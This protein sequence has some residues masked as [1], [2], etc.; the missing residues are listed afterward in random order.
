MLTTTP[1]QP[2]SAIIVDDHYHAIELLSNHITKAPAIQLQQ[3]F[4][5]PVLA[6]QFVQNTPVDLVFLDVDMQELSGLEFLDII[7]NKS[8][9]ILTTGHEKYAKN[10]YEYDAVIDYL[11]K[12]IKLDRFLK[13]VQK[14]VNSICPGSAAPVD[15]EENY[16]LVKTETK[17]KLQKIAFSE[18]IYIASDKNYVSI[19]T[20]DKRITS[21]MD[22]TALH[23]RLPQNQ[24]FRVHKSYIIALNKIDS[25]EKSA[26]I[27]K[28]ANREVA[29][30]IGVSYKGAFFAG[31]ED[32][33]VGGR[34]AGRLV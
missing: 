1:M 23:K 7:G 3:A 15:S 20:D 19:Y 2:I 28:K 21:L 22:M 34:A 27:I 25:I 26:I 31:L 10:G 14:A 12:P 18:I 4:T 30:P 9:V 33:I 11:L 32:K 6:L 16:L 5:N 24:F 17:S 29:I 8:K 13:S